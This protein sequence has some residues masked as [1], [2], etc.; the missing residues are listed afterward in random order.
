M[1]SKIKNAVLYYFEFVYIVTCKKY[2]NVWTYINFVCNYTLPH[3]A[4][5][6]A[7]PW[8]P[9]QTASKQNGPGG[10]HVAHTIHNISH[11]LFVSCSTFFYLS[12][13]VDISTTIFSGISS[14]VP[15][16][17]LTILLPNNKQKIP[18][19]ESV[20][21]SLH[22]SWHTLFSQSVTV[23]LQCLHHLTHQDASALTISI[24]KPLL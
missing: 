19:Q 18:L 8:L 21:N 16:T 6:F 20:G 3:G 15:A 11:L 2:R 24:L 7:E 9:Q 17:E 4:N 5:A 13:L 14:R 1:L 10:H 22:H 12:L 23:I